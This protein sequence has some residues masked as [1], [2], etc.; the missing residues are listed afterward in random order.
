MIKNI[1]PRFL[2]KAISCA[3]ADTCSTISMMDIGEITLNLTRKDCFSLEKWLSP[4]ELERLHS[5]KFQKRKHEWLSGRLCAKTAITDFRTLQAKDKLL[6]NQIVIDNGP[7]GRPYISLPKSVVG[8]ESCDISISHSNRYALAIAADTA[9]GIDVQEPKHTLSR[10][11]ERFCLDKEELFFDKSTLQG[12]EMGP[13]TLLWAAKESIRK[14]YSNHFI[15]EFLQ[16]ETIGAA[17]D[18]DGWWHITL[19]HPQISPTV[20]GGFFQGYGIAVCISQELNDAGI[21]RS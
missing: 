8:G 17:R 1:F 5:L 3:F 14:A 13:L 16:L 20:I 10:V 6:L 18:R 15:P 12:G 7:S 4:A 19:S 11:K 21:T 2:L 9:C